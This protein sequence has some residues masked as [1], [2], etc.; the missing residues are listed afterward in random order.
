[1]VDRKQLGRLKRD[2]EEWNQWRKENF[3]EV[4][5]SGADLYRVNLRGANLRDA[6]LRDA[7]LREAILKE[8]DFSNADLSYADLNK[9]YLYKTNLSY[10]DLNHA[11]LRDTY[12]VRADLSNVDLSRA[13]LYNADLSKAKLYDAQL[14]G[15]DLSKVKLHNAYLSGADFSSANLSEAELIGA[16]LSNA[17]L[18][19]ADLI[20]ANLSSADLRNTNFGNAKLNRADL[21]N[22]DLSNSDLSSAQLKSVQ[23]ISTNFNN[24]NLTGACI[25]DWNIN[26][27]TQFEHVICEYIYLKSE[28]Q[29]SKWDDRERRPHDYKKIFAPGDFARFIQQAGETFDLIFSEGI[30]WTAFAQTFQGLQIQTGSDELSI[31]GIEKKRDGSFVIK[32][33]VPATANKAALE[34]EFWNRYQPLL[35]AKEAEY[36]AQLQEMKTAHQQ[37]LIQCHHHY[38]T[39]LMEMAK[40]LGSRPI[41]IKSMTDQSRQIT[42]HGNYHE[43]TTADKY[44][45]Q[46]GQVGNVEVNQSEIQSG[47]KVTG[48]INEAEQP[49]LS[50]AAAEIQN[51]LEQLDTSYSTETIEQLA[52]EAITQID[53]NPKLK[54]KIIRSLKAGGVAAIEQLLN[55]PAASLVINAIKEWQ[56]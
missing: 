44:Y 13:N 42:V 2:V 4:D 52:T 32:V 40:I 20:R 22:A 39:N 48:F 26:S 28:P 55:H 27:E 47:A 19:R 51:L 6:N 7:N 30:D 45:E 49:N 15:A 36:R 3:E 33:D 35:E 50:Q 12:L 11:N 21:S 24:V 1:M 31:Q 43:N 38:N 8:A 37:E 5:L 25:Q 41:N 34:E 46:P 54:E 9:A 18:I 17:T 56:K 23:A 29:N 53:N 10:A 16:N 14:I